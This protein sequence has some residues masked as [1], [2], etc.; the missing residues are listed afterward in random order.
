MKEP[1]LL[2]DQEEDKQLPTEQEA[3]ERVRMQQG[4][5]Q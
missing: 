3:L 1:K 2:L 4:E 5:E